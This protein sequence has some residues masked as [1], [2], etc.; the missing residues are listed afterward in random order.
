M[1]I[2]CPCC[3]TDF[4]VEAGI[5]DV[6]ARNAVKMAFS[7]TPF[8]AL[9]LSYVQLFKPE[10]HALSMTKLVKILD[11][12]IPMIQAGKIEHK[13]RVWAA[14]LRV[15][16]DGLEKTLANRDTLKLPL[17]NHK[18]LFAIIAGSANEAEDKAEKQTEARKIGGASRRQEP[19]PKAAKMSKE[20][21]D[22][23]NQFLNKT[24][25]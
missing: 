20:V 11:E 23:L 13:G 4:P 14:P 16:Q 22:Q 6:A 18:Y 21:K 24:I 12:I 15:W 10:K 9:L 19:Q 8:G 17:G 3:Q 1:R 7:T 5:N 25:S 2:I